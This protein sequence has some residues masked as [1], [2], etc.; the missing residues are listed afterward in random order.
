VFR[1]ESFTT[2]PALRGLAHAMAFA[3]LTL[4]ARINV[5]VCTG[6][7]MTVRAMRRTC[8]SGN[9]RIA[10]QKVLALSH[11]LKVRRVTASADAA[12][13]VQLKADWDWADKQLIEVPVNYDAGGSPGASG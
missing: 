5:Q 9:D 12:Q 1:P 8:C 4:A 3:A 2:S 13:V 6:I 11:R 7:L 10:S